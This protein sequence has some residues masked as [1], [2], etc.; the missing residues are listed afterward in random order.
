VI[1]W[2]AKSQAGIALF[3]GQR[4]ATAKYRA[5]VEVVCTRTSTFVVGGTA[6]AFERLLTAPVEWVLDEPRQPLAI[7]ARQRMPSDSWSERRISVRSEGVVHRSMT[8]GFSVWF[9]KPVPDGAALAG[10]RRGEP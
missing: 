3:P 9:P 6:G 1:A 4:T 8:T 2:Q 5:G 10:S 7:G